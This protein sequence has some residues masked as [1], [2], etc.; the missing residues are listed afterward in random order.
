MVEARYQARLIPLEEFADRVWHLRETKD[1]AYYELQLEPNFFEDLAI[2]EKHG[3]ISFSWVFDSMGEL[4][5]GSWERWERFADLMEE[6][7][8]VSGLYENFAALA[9][10]C[11]EADA[12]TATGGQA[13]GPL[14]F[15]PRF[16]I[17]LGRWYFGL[18][19]HAEK[20]V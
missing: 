19:R 9:K 2:L 4:V 12:T 20:S 14:S 15:L 3:G 16:G 1:R 6:K 7:T 11:E 18:G 17:T 5:P 10:R 8:H 13:D